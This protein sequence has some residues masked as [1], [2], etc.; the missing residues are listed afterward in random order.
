MDYLEKLNDKQKEAVLHMDGPCLVIA[1]AGSGKTKVL[2]TR[3]ANLIDNGVE[4][5]NILAITFTNKAAKEMRERLEVLVPNNNAFVGTF[6]SFGVRVIRENYEELGLQKNFTI[7]DSDDVTSVIKKIMKDRDIDTKECAPAY[8]RNRISFIKNENLS[9]GEIEK[10]F[11]TPP[12]KIAYEVYKE[13]IK[14]LKINNSVDFDDL[15]LLP[16]KLF[17]SNKE[18]LERYQNRFKYILIDE[19]QDTNEVQYRLTKLLGK[20]YQN[21]FVVGDANQCVVK[22]TKINTIDGEKNIENLTENDKILTAIGHGEVDYNKIE[23]IVPTKYEGKVVKI[24]T[25]SGNTIT[26]TPDHTMFYKLPMEEGKFYVYMMFKNGLGFRIGQTRSYRSDGNNIVNGLK[27]RLNQE[28]GD[29][30]WLLR[31]C[32]NAIE[33]SY[34]EQFYATTYG[35]PQMCFHNIGRNL[36]FEDED[37]KKFYNSIDTNLRASVLMNEEMLSFEHPHYSKSGFTNKSVSNRIININYLSTTKA[38]NRNYYAS[39][40]S[41]NTTS[42]EYRTILENAGFPVRNGK[43]KDFR[44]ETERLTM[45]EAYD[46]GIKIEHFIKDV[47]IKEKIRLT[48]NDSFNFIKAGSLRVGMTLGVYHE[49][50]IIEDSIKNIEKIDYD[51]FVYDISIKPT[52]NFIANNI[53]VHNCIYGFRG[54]NFRN[55]LNFEKDYPNSVVVSLEQNYRST[56]NILNAANSVIR[57]NKERKDMRLYSELGEGVKLKYIR[58]Y[59]EKNEAEKVIDEIKRLID[60]GYKKKDMAIFYRTNGQARVV[61]EAFLKANIPYKVVGSFY[62]YSRKEIKDLISYLRLIL[63]KDD[64][65]SLRRVINVPKRKIGASTVSNIENMARA[66]GVS[67]FDAIEKGKELEFKNLILELQKDSESLSLTELIDDVLD[68]SGLRQELEMEHT[69]ES[70]LRLEN[71]EEFK[72]ITASFEEQTGSVNLEDFLAEISLVAD[73]SEHKETNDEVTLMTIH[74]AKG[75]EFDI[76]FLLGME[77]GIFPHQNSFTEEGGIEEERRLCYVGI[78]RAREKLYLTNAKRRMLYGRESINQPSRFIDEIDKNYI[79]EDENSVKEIKK[80]HRESMYNKEGDVTYNNGDIVNH[81]TYGPGVVIAVDKMIVT[82]A[83]QHGVGVKKL[84]KN[85]KSLKKVS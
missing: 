31:R 33:A 18:I 24:T 2:T 28:H 81:D 60:A 34:Y 46:F 38:K 63:N 29:K 62:F 26:C 48:E 70:D 82:V 6:H 49:G 16:V 59:D 51:D 71:L 83:F 56:T 22:G 44:I 12:E 21:V 41:F 45:D 17:E 80:I 57:N 72:S 47:Y 50:K 15:L 4:S 8:I 74:S 7:L 55:I 65:I 35:L 64:E 53:V 68:K 20:K 23:K 14:L 11:N 3:I 84:M 19:Y 85:H 43:N 79:E 58:A 42:D 13:Y 52:R 37:I 27:Q 1:G 54:S 67:M 40:I 10:F 78:T 73:M 76:V 77:E 69:L 75:L 30:I 36:Q 32:E 9:I 5:Y 25:E 61:E 66:M 39:R